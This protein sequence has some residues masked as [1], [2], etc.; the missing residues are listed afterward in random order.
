LR[1]LAKRCVRAKPSHD[2]APPSIVA[3]L[4]HD[5][6]PFIAR[7]LGRSYRSIQHAIVP[8]TLVRSEV[9]MKLQHGGLRQ[10]RGSNEHGRRLRVAKGEIDVARI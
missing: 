9:V 1:R 3:S 7:L 10:Y 8:N 4:T 2:D 6:I 5:D